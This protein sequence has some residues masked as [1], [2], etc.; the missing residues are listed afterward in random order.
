MTEFIKRP[1][2]QHGNKLAHGFSAA[3]LVFLYATFATKEDIAQVNARC[4]RC[5]EKRSAQW[6]RLMDHEVAL[7]RI[8]VTLP[9]RETNETKPTP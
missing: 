4:D 3:M 1:V 5:E 8:G 7:A 2:A 9:M 6:R